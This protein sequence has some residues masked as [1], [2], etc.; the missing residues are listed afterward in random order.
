MK[1]R[2]FVAAAATAAALMTCVNS[3]QAADYPSRPIQMI[4]PWG[5]G[6]GTDAVGRII[7]SVMQ[8]DL[9]VP[10][11]VVNRTGGS[12]VV[13]HSTIATAKPDGYTIGIATVEIGMLHWQ[14]LTDMSYKDFDIL[15]IVNQDPAGIS[16][17]VQLG[18]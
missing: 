9:G 10:I 13:G 1:R 12:G 2:T 14:G 15:G 17:L 8:E 11:N 7:A 16:V 4:V 5:A 6:G 18:L 3:V